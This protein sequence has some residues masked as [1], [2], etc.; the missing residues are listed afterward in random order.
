MKTLH[1][2]AAL[3]KHIAASILGAVH[4]AVASGTVLTTAEG[5]MKYSLVTDQAHVSAEE[6]FKLRYILPEYFQVGRPAK[7][8]VETEDADDFEKVTGIPQ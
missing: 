3:A 7:K 8:A 5:G 1:T 4:E 2:N 6:K